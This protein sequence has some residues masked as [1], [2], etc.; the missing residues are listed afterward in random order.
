MDKLLVLFTMK[1][2]PHCVTMKDA[3]KESN[4]EFVERDIDEYK[5]EYNI[6]V[7]VTENEFVPAFMIIENVNTEIPN[8][9]L[10]APERDYNEITEGVEIIKNHLGLN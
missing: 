6:F 1:G 9:L 3:L 8:S 4:I 7:E 2:C 5:D 10:F